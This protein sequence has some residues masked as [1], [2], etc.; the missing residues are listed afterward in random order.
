MDD[1]MQ[2]MMDAIADELASMDITN[3][4]LPNPTLITFY[5]NLV[6][7]TIWLD[8]CVDASW[9]EFTRLI[10][11]WN[12]EDV[13]IPVEDRKPIKLFFF[14]PGGDLDINNSF[15]D[16]LKLSKTPTIGINMGACCSAAAFCFLSCH[17]RYM[18]PKSYFL[19]HTGSADNIRGT[20]EQVQSFTEHYNKQVQGLKDYLVNDIG[21]DKKIVSKG[22]KGEWYID[23]DEALK[24]E[25]VDEV[26]DDITMLM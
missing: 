15:I 14:S 16:I 3:M 1:Y 11:Q 9:L 25:I 13:A 20:A 24:L 26:V 4:K 7:R 8:S 12:E 6:N 22:M 17:K 10:L 2:E 5:R 21:I 18:L 23:A 19:L